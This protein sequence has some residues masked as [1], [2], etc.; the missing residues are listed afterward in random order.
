VI[1]W[2]NRFIDLHSSEAGRMPIPEKQMSVNDLKQMTGNYYGISRS[3][4]QN[5]PMQVARNDFLRNPPGRIS[6]FSAS[7]EHGVVTTQSISNNR[8]VDHPVTRFCD[9]QD[10]MFL[11]Q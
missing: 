7:T 10:V 2:W 3:P 5:E 8:G 6:F 9:E 1:C 4:I 11:P